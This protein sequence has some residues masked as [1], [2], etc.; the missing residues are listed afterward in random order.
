MD[1]SPTQEQHARMKYL[2]QMVSKMRVKH[3]R[4]LL[5]IVRQENVSCSDLCTEFGITVGEFVSAYIITR[6]RSALLQF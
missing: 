6:Q 2:L 5:T 1:V 3:V 4:S